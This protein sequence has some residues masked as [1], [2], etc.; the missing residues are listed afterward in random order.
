MEVKNEKLQDRLC[1]FCRDVFF[2]VPAFAGTLTCQQ[3]TKAICDAACSKWGGG[4]QSN[5]DGIVTCN[6]A[7]VTKKYQNSKL[8]IKPLRDGN[9]VINL[10]KRPIYKMK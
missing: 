1:D 10:R 2:T 5:P 4:M 9:W 3:G 6:Y 8:K 7:F